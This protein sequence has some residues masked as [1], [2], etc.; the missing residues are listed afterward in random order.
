MKDPLRR[1]YARRALITVAVALAASGCAGGVHSLSFPNPPSTTIPA[2]A[3]PAT[4]PAGLSSIQE[5]AVPGVTTTTLPAVPGGSSTLNGTVTGPSGPVAGAVVQVDRFVGDAFSSAQATT[6]ADGSWS[7]KNIQGGDYRVR[8]WQ[9]PSLDMNTPAIIFLAAGQSQTVPLS[10]TSYQSQQVQ[11]AINPAA[12]TVG[13]P[14][15]LVVQVT[16]PTVNA[17]GVFSAPP[18]T[19]AS[20]TLVNGPNW[21]VNNG[22]PLP[23]NGAGQATFEVECTVAG[24]DGLQAQV[25]ANPPVTLQMPACGAAPVTTTT[26][27]SPFLPTSTTCPP[28]SNDT[29][30]TLDFGSFC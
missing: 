10:L 4:L 2:P 3:A 23:T 29:T 19:N 5:A 6:A 21:Q 14:A 15:D 18:V 11:V 9:A 12:P 13:Q 25:G 8:A 1:W 7:I 17:G 30:T 22:N 20:V 27:V 16:A 24:D 28:N 26:N